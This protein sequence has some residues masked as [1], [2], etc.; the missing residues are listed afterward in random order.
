MD[1]VD[2]LRSESVGRFADP[3]REK[4]NFLWNFGGFL[5]Q[6]KRHAF[7]VGGDYPII[8]ETT[9][10]EKHIQVLQKYRAQTKIL[11]ALHTEVVFSNRKTARSLRS[12]QNPTAG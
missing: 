10:K 7:F 2:L 6:K 1:S 4:A 11:I 12:S 8:P 5:R 3:V 9:Q